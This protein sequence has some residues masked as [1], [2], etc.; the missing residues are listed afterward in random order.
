MATSGWCVVTMLQLPLLFVHMSVPRM[1][2][3]FTF[4]FKWLTVTSNFLIFL[5][6]FK[7]THISVSE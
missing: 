4:S 1:L 2:F 7:Y 3:D 5:M 6:L